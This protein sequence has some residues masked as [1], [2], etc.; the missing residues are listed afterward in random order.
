VPY[1]SNDSEQ[2]EFAT[3]REEVTESVPGTAGYGRLLNVVA[4]SQPT[5]AF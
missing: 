3:K 1:G 2:M 5:I 4:S